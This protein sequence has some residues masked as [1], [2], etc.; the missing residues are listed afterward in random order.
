MDSARNLTVVVSNLLFISF[1]K[2]VTIRDVMVVFTIYKRMIVFFL[3]MNVFVGMYLLKEVNEDKGEIYND[4]SDINVITDSKALLNID[5]S[6]MSITANS[7]HVSNIDSAHMSNTDSAHMSNTHSAHMPNPDSAHILV[8]L[9]VS[10]SLHDLAPTLWHSLDV[11]R[12]VRRLHKSSSV[13]ALEALI[14]C[15]QACFSSESWYVIAF[16]C[17]VIYYLLFVNKM[18]NFKCQKINLCCLF[19]FQL[20]SEWEFLHLIP[21]Y[22]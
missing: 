3:N 15:E 10:S 4:D 9:D 6:H 2:C 11:W 12:C 1:N 7:A 22:A 17:H 18:N 16:F 13:E 21:F 5:S 19:E 14:L 20:V 8:E